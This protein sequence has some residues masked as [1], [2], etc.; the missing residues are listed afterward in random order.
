MQAMDKEYQQALVIIRRYDE[1]VSEKAS[2]TSLIQ[3]YEHLKI[4]VEN[5]KFQGFI[6]DNTLQIQDLRDDLEKFN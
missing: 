2:K 4:F 1:I 3:V 6:S 5:K